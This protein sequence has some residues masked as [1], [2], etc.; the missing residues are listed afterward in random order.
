MRAPLLLLRTVADAATVGPKPPG[1]VRMSL[2][3]RS[4]W[5]APHL[6]NFAKSVKHPLVFLDDGFPFRV[7]SNVNHV[8]MRALMYHKW[9]RCFQPMS[10]LGKVTQ[11][12]WRWSYTDLFGG[13]IWRVA[14]DVRDT[15]GNDGV[16]FIWIHV[17]PE[18]RR[19][20][21]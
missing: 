2:A 13:N 1:G 19:Q 11:L 17:S 20:H 6:L 18:D 21:I 15:G 10:L 4:L 3:V 16:S 7:A 12:F 5:Q 8:P 9:I 14:H